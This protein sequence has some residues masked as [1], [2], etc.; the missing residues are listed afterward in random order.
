MRLDEFGVE[1]EG[2]LGM[3][4]G[5]EQGA[6]IVVVLAS[7]EVE[8]RQIAR[9]AWIVGRVASRAREQRQSPLQATAAQQL[10]D[11]IEVPARGVIDRR[12]AR[13][14]CAPGSHKGALGTPVEAG[15][16]A[17]LRHERVRG[18]CWLA[19]SVAEATAQTGLDRSLTS[20]CCGEHAQRLD[21]LPADG[22]RCLK[23]HLE[24]ERH[25]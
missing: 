13:A 11:A 22:N 5:V 18:V 25:E 19:G 16:A 14:Q 15:G 2:L 12:L 17:R 20:G 9:Q 10:Q 7:G 4:E 24:N 21:G 23:Q 3:V 6:G 1:A 8:R